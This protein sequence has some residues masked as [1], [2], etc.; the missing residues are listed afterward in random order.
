LIIA[1]IG[2]AVSTI[3]RA[4]EAYKEFKDQLD[5]KGK[6]VAE[7][8][9]KRI[10]GESEQIRDPGARLAYVK[11]MA[12][13]MDKIWL[14][15]SGSSPSNPNHQGMEARAASAAMA[16]DELKKLAKEMESPEVGKDAT[17]AITKYV[18]KLKEEAITFG[19]TA[20]QAERYK[21]TKMAMNEQQREA[22]EN[23]LKEADAIAKTTEAQRELQKA[24]DDAAEEAKKHADAIDDIINKL[25][26]EAQG[27]DDDQMLAYT[28]MMHG[29]TQEMIDY[30]IELKHARDAQEEWTDE[31]EDTVQQ[32]ERLETVL[33]SLSGSAEALGRISAFRDSLVGGKIRGGDGFGAREGRLNPMTGTIGGPVASN[34][35]DR[36]IPLLTEMRDLL[37]QIED[38]PTVEVGEEDGD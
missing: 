38:Q 12:E 18:D 37:R 32:S 7:D 15:Q 27:F 6:S 33:A 10:K 3:Y 14:D 29:A 11:K 2:T 1:L 23:A 4:K 30:A 36:T 16:R 8:S 19:M 13:E 34:T 5:E 28:L 22:I 21:I 9:V 17:E 26:L 25:E 20:E 35:Q 24:Q 31:I